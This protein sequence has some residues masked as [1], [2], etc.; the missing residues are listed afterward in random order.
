MDERITFVPPLVSRISYLV[1]STPPWWPTW[2]TK[3]L[4]G[5]RTDLGYRSPFDMGCRTGGRR[6]SSRAWPIASCH[7]LELPKCP[8]DGDLGGRLQAR[9][10]FLPVF[11]QRCLLPAVLV[12][13]IGPALA[14]VASPTAAGAGRGG[15]GG[16]EEGGTAAVASCR[17][18]CCSFCLLLLAVSV[19]LSARQLLQ[20][21]TSPPVAASASGALCF[22]SSRVQRRRH[23]R[24]PTP[25]D[26]VQPSP[27][28]SITCVT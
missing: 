10:A 9:V 19:L 8:H 12:L 4:R 1:F 27:T 21:S 20:L 18:R 22:P 17:R 6:K 25:P 7:L 15:G 5:H 24:T 16:G 26:S 2:Y 14:P 13:V 3:W 23:L 28:T 11:I